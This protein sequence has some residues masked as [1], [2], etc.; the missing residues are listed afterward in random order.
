MPF[1]KRPGKY[2]LYDPSNEKENC[3]VGFIANI[4]GKKNHTIITDACHILSRMEHRG[5]RGAGQ[6]PAP[7]SPGA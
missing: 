5:A 1:V 2:G 7:G 6:R 4:K 3:G